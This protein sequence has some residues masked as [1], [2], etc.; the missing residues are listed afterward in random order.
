MANSKLMGKKFG[1]PPELQKFTGDQTMSY[2]M[3][4]K[5]KNFFDYHDSSHPY[6]EKKG[7]DKMKQFIESTLNSQRGI[8]K[9][10]AEI[11][12]EF[13]PNNGFKKTHTKDRQT[14]NVTKVGGVPKV[15]KSTSHKRLYKGEMLY[16]QEIKR[17]Q[18]LITYK[19]IL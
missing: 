19:S 17:I 5:L 2:S 14:K 11:K 18:E 15:H 1:L 9:K 16:E 3:M 13:T 7:G 10:S 4:K 12:S 6:Y 8:V